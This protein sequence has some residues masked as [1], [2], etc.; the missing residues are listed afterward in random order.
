MLPKLIYI[1]QGTT[2]ELHLINLKKAVTAGATFVQLRLKEL[3]PSVVLETAQ[4]AAQVC[5][6]NNVLLAINDYPEIA[7]AVNAGAVHVGLDDQSVS[8]VR[9]LLPNAIIGGT[10]NTIAD[11]RQRVNEG[12]DYIG[13]GPFRYTVTKKK[14]SPVLGTD[15]YQEIL[16]IMQKEGLTV[17]VYAIGGIEATD[18]QPLL[19]VGLYGV[20]ISGAITHS[21]QP[22]HILQLINTT[23]HVEHSR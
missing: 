5:R 20:A 2:P 21:A 14:L 18:I 10:A 19:A 3:P 9:E 6:Q 4:Q 16:S 22:E 1:T 17:P 7:K 23:A 15:G 8:A 13:L 12:V 11:V